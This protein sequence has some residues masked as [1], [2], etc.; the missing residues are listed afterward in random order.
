MLERKERIEEE[1]RRD[2][3][4]REREEREIRERARIE[5]ERERIWSEIASRRSESQEYSDF[6][7][8]SQYSDMIGSTTEINIFFHLC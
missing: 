4:R 1:E 5:K 8:Y 7:R 2:K 6:M 3:K